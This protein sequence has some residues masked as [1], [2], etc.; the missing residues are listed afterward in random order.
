MKLTYELSDGK[1]Q[2]LKLNLTED[3]YVE[4]KF[5]RF[6]KMNEKTDEYESILNYF[7]KESGD[8]LK[9]YQ[10]L[11]NDED[12]DLDDD[13]YDDFFDVYYN[14]DD[15]R[16]DDLRHYHHLEFD[17][18]LDLGDDLDDHHELKNDL[19][20]VKDVEKFQFRFNKTIPKIRYLFVMD[21]D[22]EFSDK[23]LYPDHK[24]D[25]DDFENV[26]NKKD[27][28]IDSKTVKNDDNEENKKIVNLKGHVFGFPI[29]IV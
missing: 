27:Q 1:I 19:K 11:E 25:I 3:N 4:T 21:S 20:K 16:D 13:F 18:D 29:G 15:D 22:I 8:D 5:C 26:K 12:I 23:F 17:E 24:Q 28:Q 10:E 14:T 2:K 6:L 9:Y 7:D